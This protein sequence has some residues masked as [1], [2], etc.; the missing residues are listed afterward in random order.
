MFNKLKYSH[1]LTFILCIVI[2]IMLREYFISIK[3]GLHVDESLSII[4][5]SY[6]SIGFSTLGDGFFGMTGDEI[7]SS[8]YLPHGGI[9]NAFKDIGKLWINNRDLPHSNLYYSF[10]RLWMSPLEMSSV[11]NIVFWL[12]QL[13]VL[14]MCISFFFT[15]K[16]IVKLTGHIHASILCAFIAYTSY[17]AISNTAFL[18][19]YQFQE[20]IFVIYV[21]YTYI[22]FKSSEIKYSQ[23]AL[24]AFITGV[25]FLTGYFSIFLI[26]PSSLLL[27]INFKKICGDSYLKKLSFYFI[28]SLIFSF[29]IY[30][31]YFNINYRTTEAAGKVFSFQ[32]NIL[33]AFKIYSD[34]ASSFPILTILVILA[35][36]YTIYYAVKGSENER[37]RIW[38]FM[39]ISV[40]I[41]G[42]IYFAPYKM[43][44]YIYPSI[45][46]YSL[47]FSASFLCIAKLNKPIAYI[48]LII[49]SLLSLH[50]NLDK[51]KVENLFLKQSNDCLNIHND[52]SLIIAKDAFKFNTLSS[53][54]DAKRIYT[55]I[56]LKDYEDGFNT[57]PFDV[58]FSDTEI[59]L[60][61]YHIEY[62]KIANIS[63]YF[64][65]YKRNKI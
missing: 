38:I 20:M 44:R 54:M 10:L 61:D 37:F 39:S 55:V 22:A 50:I 21:Y 14:F 65:V 11:S 29:A 51:N 1:E 36:L 59:N 2:L 16:L 57:K 12:A 28:T 41:I 15:V 35:S 13:N 25:T 47:I 3:T 63:S 18:R 32:D 27:L 46:F 5:S 19:P 45:P 60:D 23:L 17:L 52:S 43:S 58:V 56:T 24:Y 31:R 26:I 64:I 40:F 9:F 6:K 33:A 30:P 53:C 4:L 49:I 48:T 42:A 8:M 62:K 34:I 7:R